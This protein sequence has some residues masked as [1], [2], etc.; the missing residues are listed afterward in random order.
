[1]AASETLRAY[2]IALPD[3]LTA[4]TLISNLRLNFNIE[5]EIISAVTPTSF[6]CKDLGKDHIHGAGRNR[7]SCVENAIS[8]SHKLARMIALENGFQWSLILEEDAL[9]QNGLSE[10]TNALQVLDESE[11]GS[12]SL[13]LHLFPEQFGVLVRS[14]IQEV[15]RVLA[16]PDFAVAYAL[17]SQALVEVCRKTKYTKE[18]VADW[19]NFMKKINWFAVKSSMILHPDLTLPMNKSSSSIPRK[20]I[21]RS[22]SPISR[23]CHLRNMLLPL[24]GIGKLL[25]LSFGNN[26]IA[27]ERIRSVLIC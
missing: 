7:I 17:N 24:F 13:G 1:M 6:G 4:P 12:D 19:P 2:V 3:S 22:K 9:P 10:L 14:K 8:E 15:Y 27:S 20:L 23:Y 18:Q 26:S 11:I 21:S 16:L 5:A 25:G